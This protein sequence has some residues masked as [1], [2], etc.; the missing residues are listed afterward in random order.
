MNCQRFRQHVGNSRHNTLNRDGFSGEMLAHL[1]TCAECTN[2]TEHRR[3]LALSFQR[4][5][6][7][8]PQ[9]PQTLDSAVLE[10]YR[11]HLATH[12]QTPLHRGTGRAAILGYS[13]AVIAA[14]VIVILLLSPRK[15][16]VPRIQTAQG[17]QPTVTIEIPDRARNGTPDHAVS[18]STRIARK[19]LDES[20]YRRP[21]RDDQILLNSGFTSLMYCD[22]LS[23][24]GDM[25]I[26][27]VQVSPSMLGP[28]TAPTDAVGTVLADVLVGS[29]GIARGIRFEQ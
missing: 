23:C 15:T 4:I 25:E 24:A 20:V 21:T 5:R 19:K 22:R 1:D 29:D 12:D 10:N 18:R 27:R 17:P 16:I 9:F 14:V 7:A 26:V 6:A 11:G 8:A 3:E 13:A 28:P 2:Y